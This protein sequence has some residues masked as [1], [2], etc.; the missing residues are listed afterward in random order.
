MEV[1]LYLFLF[2]LFFI[3]S[4]F[5][6]AYF[7]I[8]LYSA[9]KGAPYVPTRAKD[10][11]DI[12]SHADLKSGQTFIEL[13]CGDGR[14]TR[15]AVKQYG[16]KGR[17]IDVNQALIL[18]ARLKSWLLGVPNVHFE[19]NNVKTMSY[20]DID[21]IY[22]FLLPSLIET[23]HNRLVREVK[24]DT[25]IISHGFKVSGW[26]KY[27]TYKRS[28]RTFPTYYYRIHTSY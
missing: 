6:A 4:V 21:V 13:G 8:L 16:V 15:E 26:E 17:G 9:F 22:M 25:L 10:I 1:Y 12:L 18:W 2:V 19:K 7:I 11:Q 20:A 3:F 5:F 24:P 23:F 27:L 14:V 28:S